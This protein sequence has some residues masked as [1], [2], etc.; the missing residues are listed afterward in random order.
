[1]MAKGQGTIEYLVILAVIVILGLVVVS[2]ILNLTNF[3]S[4]INSTDKIGANIGNPIAILDAAIDSQGEAIFVLRSNK[5]ENLSLSAITVEGVDAN[6]SGVIPQID[7]STIKF[8]GLSN[9]CCKGQL[10][11]KKCQIKFYYTTPYGSDSTEVTSIVDC[12]NDIDV[13]CVYSYSSWSDCN[14]QGFQSRSLISSTP[15][16]CVK[17]LSLSQPCTYTDITPPQIVLFSPQDNNYWSSST[18]INFDYNVSDASPITSC[19]LLADGV[20]VSTQ[21]NPSTGINTI[22]YH[23]NDSNHIWGITCTDMFSNTSTNSPRNISVD[24]NSYEINNCVQL[25]GIDNNLTGN[26]ILMNDIN[27]ATDTT[28]GGTLYNAGAG[29]NPIGDYSGNDFLGILDGNKHKIY[30]LNIN[31]PSGTGIGL[32]SSIGTSGS[33]KKIE[34]LD[35]NVNGDNATGILA[36]QCKGSI[37][38]A[39]VGGAITLSYAGGGM[40][41]ELYGTISEAYS[42]AKITT[43]GSSANG[44]GGIVGSLANNSGAIITNSYF[45]GNI[46][47][48]R[49]SAAGIAAMGFAGTSITNSYSSGPISA[50]NYAG[51]LV[52]AA[53]GVSV[54]NSFSVSKITTVATGGGVLAYVMTATPTGNYWDTILT[55][56]NSCYRLIVGGDS[57][58]GCTA[59]KN[60]PS[61]YYNK[62]NAP[63]NGNWDFTNVWDQNVNGYPVL[64]W[65]SS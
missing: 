54:T 51:G 20:N 63:M 1:M 10:G 22:A 26:Y 57:N 14:Y 30:G 25:Q 48:S 59:T 29:F 49:I 58:V 62:N 40:V 56:R 13:G 2:I 31:Q 7:S 44:L 32:F 24:A 15:S 33:V 47:T 46:Y 17:N 45:D 64:R 34:I 61:Y 50:A 6:A 65:R 53:S 23:L 60:N 42:S 11:K 16:G 8:A 21:N 38:Q 19:S 18:I 9:A 28:L 35:A 43:V 55:S 39:G 52:S 27:C 37:T 12:L 3:S 41:G 36:G 5:G 4:V